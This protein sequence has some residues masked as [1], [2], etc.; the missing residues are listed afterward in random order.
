[1]KILKVFH[2]KVTICDMAF[3]LA[4]IRLIETSPLTPK[5]RR[6]PILSRTKLFM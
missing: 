4:L 3:T 5:A 2:E 6:N 1:M